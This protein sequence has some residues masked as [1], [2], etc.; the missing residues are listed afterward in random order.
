MLKKQTFQAKTGDLRKQA[1]ALY[2][3]RSENLLDTPIGEPEQELTKIRA[4]L[5]ELQVHQIEL[6]LQNEELCQVQA[7][8]EASRNK[9]VDLYDLAP[10]GYLTL[11]QQGMIVETNL[12]CSE[13]LGIARKFLLKRGFSRFISPKYTEDYYAFHKRCFETDSKQT[14]ELELK[15]K[16]AYSSMS[17]SMV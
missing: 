16:M 13:M 17:R 10:V 14:C 12:T 6:E 9:Y 4:L 3:Q 1:E 7:E 15:R 8:L 2:D 11:D 5:H